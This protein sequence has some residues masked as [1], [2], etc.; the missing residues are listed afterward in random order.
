MKGT[1]FSAKNDY[2]YH[3]IWQKRDAGGISLHIS[4]LWDQITMKLDFF[5]FI[6]F[7]KW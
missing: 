7:D 5:K 4:R 1:I 2:S 6:I 3:L